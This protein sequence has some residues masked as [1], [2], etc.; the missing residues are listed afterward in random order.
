MQHATNDTQRSLGRSVRFGSVLRVCMS[1]HVSAERIT[2][3]G[4]GADVLCVYARVGRVKLLKAI[5]TKLYKDFRGA[6]E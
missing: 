2:S 3:T 4:C 6:C 1:V 5:R